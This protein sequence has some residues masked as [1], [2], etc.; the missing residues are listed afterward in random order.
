M[1][2]LTYTI[3][4]AVVTT[5]TVNIAV[6]SFVMPFSLVEV[7]QCSVLS[8]CLHQQVN[9]HWCLLLTSFICTGSCSAGT[10]FLGSLGLQFMKF[11]GTDL[12]LSL[13]AYIEVYIHTLS[14]YYT[15]THHFEKDSCT[16][17]KFIPIHTLVGCCY[18]VI[19][20]IMQHANIGWSV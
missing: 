19:K 13:T 6:L 10:L 5:M 4:Y 15:S 11:L 3:R 20:L 8:C 16:L 17:V 7:Y 18:T 12:L 2:L 1:H 14:E 9:L